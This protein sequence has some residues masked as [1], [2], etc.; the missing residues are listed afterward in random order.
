MK[1]IYEE[2]TPKRRGVIPPK[3]GIECQTKVPESLRRKEKAPLPEVS[4]LDVVRHYTNLSRLNYSVD[5]NFYPLGSCTMKYN[6]KVNEQVARLDGFTS[7]HP[8]LSLVPGGPE[9]VQGALETIYETEQKL[10]EITG[11][12]A[13]TLQ[14]FAGANGEFTGVMLIAAYHK[15]RG[16]VK[17]RRML[18]P[19]SAHGTNPASAMMA[20]FEITPIPSDPK[21]WVDL[22]ALEAALGDD[23]A[24]LMLTA[25][26]TVGLFDSNVGKISEMV[27]KAGGLMYYDGANLNAIMGHARPGDLGFDVVHLNM[28][29][30]FST[31]HGGGG[32]GAGAVGVKEQLVPFLPTP[33][34]TKKADGSY[35][36]GVADSTKS[37][38]HIA[39][40]FGNFCVM[41]KAYAY[42][43]QLG[44]EGIREA[45]GLAVLN[46]NYLKAKLQDTYKFPFQDQI[47]M[48]EC[49]CTSEW[50]LEKSHVN[51]LD[52][53]KMLLD[54]GYHAPTVYFPLIVHEAIMIEPTETESKETLDA[55][56]ESMKEIAKITETDPEACHRAPERT[57][58]G[59]MDEVAA[60][61]NM[62]LK[63]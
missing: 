44:A 48:H 37:M 27:H 5:T 14:P 55:F 9:K 57:P 34:V 19:D 49:V 29:K 43:L 8:Y 61:K 60:A 38:G 17:R 6:P 10:C 32:P 53:A 51:T 56:V 15:D 59:R 41:L 18:I 13:V 36:V 22:K 23:V 54:R 63:A 31:P 42:M 26:N 7:L 3:S 16:D 47:C 4:E 33:R 24:G 21:G 46:A 30:T 40:F 2:S 45:A 11:M 20:G 50:Q 1:L 28:H 12:K 62:I 58:I 39:P 25:P 35:E 52:I